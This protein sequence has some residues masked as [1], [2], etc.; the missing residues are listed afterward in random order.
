[1][2]TVSFKTDTSVLTNLSDVFDPRKNNLLKIDAGTSDGRK[3]FLKELFRLNGET[4]LDYFGSLNGHAAK[5]ITTF[6]TIVDRDKWYGLALFEEIYFYSSEIQFTV[7]GTGVCHSDRKY[8]NLSETFL[9]EFNK[10]LEDTFELKPKVSMLQGYFAT[11]YSVLLG[12]SKYAGR[13]STPLSTILEMVSRGEAFEIEVIENSSGLTVVEVSKLKVKSMLSYANRSE[14]YKKFEYSTNIIDIVGWKRPR[15]EIVDET[16]YGIEL[17]VSTDYSEKVLVDAF[18]DIF[19][20][21]KKDSSITGSKSNMGE[22]VTIPTT[23][24]QQKKM[25]ASFFKNLNEDMFDC[26]DKHNNGMHVHIDREA[27]DKDTMHLKKFCWFF[28][29]PANHK[30]LFDMSERTQ[31]SQQKYAK[32]VTA[33]SVSKPTGNAKKGALSYINAERAHRQ[34][35]KNTA[36]NLG[37]SA[38]VEVRLFKG[39]VSFASIVKNLE[40]VDALVEFTRFHNYRDMNLPAFLKWL[41]SLHTTKYRTLRYCLEEMDIDSLVK[42]AEIEKIIKASGFGYAQIVEELNKLQLNNKFSKTAVKLFNEKYSSNGKKIERKEEGFVL[43]S[44]GTKFA[45][46]NERT[47]EMLSRSR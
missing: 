41:S 29:N 44:I 26:M 10:R 15:Q 21:V 25:W 30:F 3:K 13:K 1:M 46:F 39:I 4:I 5:W 11:L 37:K 17:E 35:D 18:P 34:S 2:S 32:F 27:F 22:I 8:A 43:I 38:T 7:L 16:L 19:A 12:N 14:L 6:K 20:L 9:T 36:L 42:E 28:G 33:P 23:L 45:K 24:R 31:D 40:L 47:L